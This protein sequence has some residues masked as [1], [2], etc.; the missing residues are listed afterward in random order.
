MTKKHASTARGRGPASGPGSS[1]ALWIAGMF[2]LAVPLAA[3]SDGATGPDGDG[4]GDEAPVTFYVGNP[5][6]AS[7]ASVSGA[8]A[9]V[10]GARPPVDASQI[11][12]LEIVVESIEAHQSGSATGTAPWVTVDLNP[13]VVIDPAVLD[14][15][16]VQAMTETELPVG[17]YDMVRL[18]PESITVQFQTSSSTTPLVIGNHEY[19][20]APTEHSVEIPGGL[21]KGIL[22]PTAHFTVE[23]DGGVLL[24][25]WD[26][27]ASAASINATGS[28]KI[29]MRPV[30]NEAD[31]GDEVG[32]SVVPRRFLDRSR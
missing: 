29:L 22:V 15:G 11:A 24:I 20:P 8:R 6:P 32:L 5:G 7:A 3:C 31:P 18:I 25:M 19:E 14:A 13:S 27:D 16:E 12:S 30:F 21:D 17:D 23:N 1:R 10:S 2:A 26:A 4:S 9:S 28:G